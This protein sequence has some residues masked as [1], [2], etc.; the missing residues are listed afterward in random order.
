LKQQNIARFWLGGMRVY[1]ISGVQNMQTLFGRGNK[2]GSEDIFIQNVLPRL[3]KM[4]PQ[5]VARFT[6]D[7]SGRGKVPAPGFEST[8]AEQ[9]YWHQYEQVHTEYLFRTQHM[10]PVMDVFRGYLTETLDKFPVGQ[11][12][13]ISVM[14]FC[15][16]ELAEVAMRTLLGPTIFKLNPGFL[17]AFWEFDANVFMFTLGFPKWLYARPHEVHD[18]YISMIKKYVDSAFQNFDWESPAAE[19]PWEPH[20]GARVCREIAKWL[21]NGGFMDVSVAGALGTLLFA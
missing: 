13:T 1:L 12:R 9:R 11:S 15:K 17:D 21:R 20:F 19:L 14:N 6:N 5:H 8:P 3:Y 16:T 10:M 2:V 4:P 7:R 18:R